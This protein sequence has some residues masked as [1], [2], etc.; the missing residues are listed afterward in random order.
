[1][2]VRRFQFQLQI[3]LSP[4]VLEEMV[5]QVTPARVHLMEPTHILD[6]HLRQMV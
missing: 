1:M 5:P 4:L 2:Q 6:H 3:M